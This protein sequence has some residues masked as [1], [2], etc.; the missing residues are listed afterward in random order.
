MPT[1]ASV[2]EVQQMIPIGEVFSQV[3]ERNGD[4]AR[5]TKKRDLH[6]RPVLVLG[7]GEGVGFAEP[8]HPAFPTVEEAALLSFLAQMIGPERLQSVLRHTP[9]CSGTSAIT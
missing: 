2:F 9:V 3:R 4:V 5:A 7:A 6:W 1:D 8:E